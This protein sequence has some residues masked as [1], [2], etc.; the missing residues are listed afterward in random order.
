VLSSVALLRAV[1]VGKTPLPMADL[2]RVATALGLREP[3]TL[4]QTGNLVFGDDGRADTETEA[5][6]ERALSDRLGLATD[7]FVRSG[8]EWR[9]IVEANP[10]PREA[11]DDP[12]HLV[13]MPLKA[14]VDEARM[15]ALRSAI[16]GAEYGELRGRD[17]YL[18]YPDGIGRS[19]LTIGLIEKTLGTRG[20]GRNWNTVLKLGA[21]VQV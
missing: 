6:I 20:T 7:V 19:K 15:A 8:A 5:L 16:K 21:M 17:L 4:L 12:A 3:R 18:V 11:A 13:L 10:F 9:G 2:K 1:N 14:A